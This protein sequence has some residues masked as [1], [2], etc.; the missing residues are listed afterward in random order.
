M[1]D[2]SYSTAMM[3]KTNDVL[4][5]VSFLSHACSF[6]EMCSK[7]KLNGIVLPLIKSFQLRWK[8]LK[9][10]YYCLFYDCLFKAVMGE[11][12]WKHCLAENKRLGNTVL[13]V[14]MQAML[15]NN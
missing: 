15:R 12:N 5:I 4:N 9:V 3:V 6:S 7:C 8:L 11:Y 2:C 1:L 10:V 14:F 13:E